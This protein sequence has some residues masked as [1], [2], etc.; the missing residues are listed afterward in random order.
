MYGTN[1]LEKGA[2]SSERSRSV[3][4]PFQKPGMP[5]QSKFDNYMGR[6]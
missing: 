3:T 6:K 4:P 2:K 5:T 1:D